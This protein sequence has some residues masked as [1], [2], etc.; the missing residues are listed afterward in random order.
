MSEDLR[1]PMGMPRTGV[2]RVRE[3]HRFGVVKRMF[4]SMHAET[5]PEDLIRKGTVIYWD[6]FLSFDALLNRG[7]NG[8]TVF[9]HHVDS[10]STRGNGWKQG[11]MLVR[12]LADWHPVEIELMKKAIDQKR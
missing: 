7:T 6:F 3:Q 1:F 8:F 12:D 10:S 5:S 11:T 9:F 2:C 4:R